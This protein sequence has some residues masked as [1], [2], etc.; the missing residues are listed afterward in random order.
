MRISPSV[1]F[2]NPLQNVKNMFVAISSE[3]LSYIV[4][5]MKGGAIYLQEPRIASAFIFL[6]NFSVLELSYR[7][8]QITSWIFP[9]ETETQALVKKVFQAVVITGLTFAANI[10]LIRATGITL[11]RLVVVAIVVMSFMVK[12]NIH[13]YLEN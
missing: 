12:Y 2:E 7:I 6:V 3:W 4:T 8:A 9:K 5:K 10:T 13:T 11:N 1:S